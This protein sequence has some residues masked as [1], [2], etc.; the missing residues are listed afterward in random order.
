METGRQA[1]PL[2]CGFGLWDPGRRKNSLH[3]R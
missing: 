3:L 1:D 2:M